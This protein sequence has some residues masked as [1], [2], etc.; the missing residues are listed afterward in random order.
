MSPTVS[1]CVGSG[2]VRIPD[3]SFLEIWNVESCTA[4]FK[5]AV[6]NLVWGT[7]MLY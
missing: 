4:A 6:A 5:V 2:E 1:M 7:P 3:S